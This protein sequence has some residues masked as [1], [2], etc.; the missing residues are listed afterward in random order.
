MDPHR[1]TATDTIVALATPPGRSALGVIRVSGPQTG[2]VLSRVFRRK[3]AGPLLARRPLLGEF[4]DP[5]GQPVDTGVALLYRA[6]ASSTG[7]DLAECT[8]HG[9]VGVIRAVVASCIAAGA[10]PAEP[11]EFTMR[12]LR[13]G[14]LDLS[15]AE[16]V[17]DLVDAESAEQAR[18]A[19]RQL[20]GEV[21]EALTPLAE[22]LV[23]LL[24]EVEA[25]LDFADGEADLGLAASDAA[26]RI[27]T[28]ISS[29]RALL[30]AS[31][32][33]RRVREG[34]RVVLLGPPNAG[35]SS[36]F[37]ALLGHDR[38]IVSS[39]PGT[40]RDLIEELVVIDGLPL[41]LIDAAGV[42]SQPAGTADAEGMRRARHAAARADLVLSVYDAS[43]AWRPEP[44]PRSTDS[45]RAIA[46]LLVGTHHDLPQAAPLVAGTIA[47][48]C[49]S[50]AGL[51][52]LRQAISTALQ[53]PGP[54]PLESV[55]LA[56]ERHRAAAQQA[57]VALERGRELASG[58]ASPEL[59]CVELRD[60]LQALHSI[61]GTID[62]EQL[63]GRIFARFCIGK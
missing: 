51:D 32:P 5:T 2:I 45:G 25:S 41:V 15:Q 58:G 33:A 34:A 27:E 18:V 19:N 47:V 21:G 44:T 50:G 42:A 26:S 63:L 17:A 1:L 23:D 7:E 22:Q 40:T 36:L 13:A 49:P 62:A 52:A 35:K 28:L 24:A 54:A 59:L 6:P 31:G 29:V 14:K 11:G 56:T 37:N 9:S 57:I 3:K 20:R 38:T 4:L 12:A 55:A 46:T 39:E 60:A 10:R 53:A 30:Q 43:C 48:A 61:L 16:A 8:V